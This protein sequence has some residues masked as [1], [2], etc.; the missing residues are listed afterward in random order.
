LLIEVT[1]N[2][3]WQVS[4]QK[5]LE[6]ADAT[7]SMEQGPKI[8][9]HLLQKM[10]S[11]AF[12]WKRILK[13]LNAIDFILKH[14]SPNALGKLQMQGA[15]MIGPLATFNYQEGG[16]D[17]ARPLR[18]KALAVMDLLQNPHKLEVERAEALEYRKKFYPSSGYAGSGAGSVS[19]SGAGSMG[20]SGPGGGYTPT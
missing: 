12:E 14:G 6:L 1:S 4:N 13:S 5:M 20:S 11:P 8:V 2:D 3:T 18:E 9:D 7:N 19:S 16:A 10:K 15:P 17:R